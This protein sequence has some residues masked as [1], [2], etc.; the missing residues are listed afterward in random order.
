V[1]EA[2]DLATWTSPRWRLTT[3]DVSPGSPSAAITD[4]PNGAYSDN[5]NSSIDLNDV[6]DLSANDIEQAVL[7]FYAKW[8]IESGYDQVQVLVSTTNGIT[9]VPQC[10]KYTIEGTG[11]HITPGQPV[12]DGE[13]TEW[14]KEEISL[15]DYIGEEVKIRFQLRS[16]GGV[17]ADGFYFDALS[18]DVI[19]K[20]PTGTEEPL[21]A[22]FQIAPNPVDNLL[23]LQTELTNY[24]VELTNSLGQVVT[25]AEG[26]SGAGTLS[27]ENLPMGVYQLTVRS[28]GKQRTLKVVKQ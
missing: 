17:T 11:T 21:T 4:S 12:Y 13:Q 22:P 8:D 19:K 26:R 14:V 15:S 25:R 23:H 5:A 10:G 2:D 28:E 24:S 1:D 9:W 16:D 18:V 6:I 27:V 3:R 7:S 20:S